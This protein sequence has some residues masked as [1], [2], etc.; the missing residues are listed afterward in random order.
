M[1]WRAHPRAETSPPCA[2]VLIAAAGAGITPLRA[3]ALDLAASRDVV[4]LH[5]F[6]ERALPAEEYRILTGAGIEVIAL[7]GRRRTTR[8]WLGDLVGTVDDVTAVRALVPDLAEREALVAGPAPWC[9][10]VG[11]CLVAAGVPPERIVE[12]ERRGP[13]RP[14]VA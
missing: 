1:A 13:G 7:P 14:L 8:S 3:Q 6:R 4:L 11:R 2:K 5:R 10:L 12:H 9:A